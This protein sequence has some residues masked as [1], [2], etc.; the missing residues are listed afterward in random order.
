LGKNPPLLKLGEISG[1]R[2]SGAGLKDGAL[3]FTKGKTRG[4]QNGALPR[5]E[6]PWAKEGDNWGV[7]EAG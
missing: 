1:G 5:G 6:S 3:I 4:R 2:G 7:P